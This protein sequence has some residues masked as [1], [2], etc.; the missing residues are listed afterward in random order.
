MD[1]I[2]NLVT[3]RSAGALDDPTDKANSI[4]LVGRPEASEECVL[5]LSPSYLNSP[6]LMV[7][8]SLQEA[9][10]TSPDTVRDDEPH[11]KETSGETTAPIAI[12]AA[13]RK[14]VRVE[15]TR[16]LEASNRA[17]MGSNRG[18]GIPQSAP[19]CPEASMALPPLQ[20]L[21][22][23]GHLAPP[24]PRLAHEQ[25]P[26]GPRATGQVPVSPPEPQH[27]KI[28]P[29]PSKAV[30]LTPPPPPSK[31]IATTP[32]PLPRLPMTVVPRPASP[33]TRTPA[34]SAMKKLVPTGKTA[35]TSGDEIV[36]AVSITGKMQEPVSSEIPFPVIEPFSV[37]GRLLAIDVES[38]GLGKKH[39]MTEIACVELVNGKITG[40]V[41]HSCVNPDRDV[42]EEATRL[43]GHTRESLRFSPRFVDIASAF[44]G[45]VR[46]ATLVFHN[47]DNDVK[48]ITEGLV[49]AG[50][51][52]DIHTQSMKDT[53]LLMKQLNPT[54]TNSLDSVCM[55]FARFGIEKR[56]NGRHNAL[57][58]ARMLAQLCSALTPKNWFMLADET[59]SSDFFG[60]SQSLPSA[61]RCYRDIS[62]DGSL[63]TLTILI[64]F[65]DPV[66]EIV[67]VYARTISGGSKRRYFGDINALADICQG[68][69]STVILGDVTSALQARDLMW[70]ED[71]SVVHKSL[72]I[73]AG[74][75]IKAYAHPI[76]L[77][78]LKLHSS[79][80]LIIIFDS[81]PG[82][83]R[84]YLIS[85]LERLT[86]ANPTVTLK[87]V[88]TASTSTKRLVDRMCGAIEI[89]CVEDLQRLWPLEKLDTLMGG[90]Q[91]ARK[92]YASASPE[93]SAPALLYLKK[94]GIVQHFPPTFRF[95]KLRHNWS[96]EVLPA[97][98]VPLFKEGRIVGIHRIFCKEDGSSLADQYKRQRKVSLGDAVGVE[99]KIYQGD[100]KGNASDAAP[101]V[102]LVSEGI[103]N[104]LVIRDVLLETMKKLPH[105]A[106]VM[107]ERLGINGTYAIKS[108]V[109][110][111]GLA[112]IPM[113]PETRVV[114]LVA[115]NDGDNVDVKRTLREAV[116]R[117]IE[118]GL[119]VRIALPE[120]EN[121]AK[122][123]LNDVY[124]KTASWRNSRAVADVL[125]HAVQIDKIGDIGEDS[126]PLQTVIQRLRKTRGTPG[127]K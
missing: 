71:A 63:E 35:N 69:Q 45:F 31:T 89:L 124:T 53:Y 12:A 97:M 15:P 66:G 92:L 109:G 37:T 106:K 8:E 70:G 94:R 121:M 110:V 42:S 82:A 60:T 108:C 27:M 68:N 2:N 125:C 83:A 117:F 72:D 36:G 113:H 77:S 5:K 104:A 99:V 18:W 75:C 26:S 100:T 25:P 43:T 22:T 90:I 16:E 34:T 112:G 49:A 62:P 61:F 73:R 111:N 1:S 52:L 79:T 39:R 84:K 114:V 91:W 46:D 54:G 56:E 81:E 116:Q 21:E 127:S 6:P 38:T 28:P 58:D 76:A 67:G 44:A 7:I 87:I 126:E 29:P 105:R 59:P 101:S 115:D 93:A 10:L 14:V 122:L 102:V 20:G 17:V 48:W 74:F 86:K 19:K 30:A 96:S 85:L 51:N 9:G 50:I 23:G 40:R 4:I 78:E 47:S 120:A 33:P 13:R 88:P 80:S 32:P 64:A 119:V 103:E 3:L 11:P 24:T 65:R 118:G 123:D 95:A 55:R 98:L 107:F 57:V 41:F